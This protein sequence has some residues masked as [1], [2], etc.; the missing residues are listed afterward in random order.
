MSEVEVQFIGSGDAFGSGGRFQTCIGVRWPT[1]RLLL[2]CGASSLVAMRRLGVDPADFDTI[3]ISHLHG[4]HFGGLPFFVLDGEFVSKRS[5]PLTVVGPP[6]IEQ[7]VTTAMEV[8]FVGSATA[9]RRFELRFLE[10]PP[11][12]PTP[13]GDASVVGVPVKHFSG[14]PSYAIRLEVAGKTVVYS[15][16]TAWTD[17]LI[18]TSH[19]ADLFICES[20]FFDTE[21]SN[22]LN[23]KTIRQNLDRLRCEQMVLTHLSEE[24]LHHASEIELPIA[25]DGMRIV[26]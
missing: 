15:G 1:G 19:D 7:R 16:D 18:E 22:H 3:V 25:E 14:A 23:Y 6:S 8:L 5:S 11:R 12:V 24:A 9:S 13:V 10:L 2:D 26:V 21:V 4:D 17:N 20:Y